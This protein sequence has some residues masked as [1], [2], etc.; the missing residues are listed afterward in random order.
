[1]RLGCAALAVVIAA[2]A[3]AATPPPTVAVAPRTA[4]E[5]APPLSE[6]PAVD[7]APPPASEEP[8][9]LADDDVKLTIP[10]DGLGIIPASGIAS[11]STAGK[12]IVALT[13]DSS[14]CYVTPIRR[15]TQ[16]LHLV[17]KDR[18]SRTIEIL[19]VDGTTACSRQTRLAVGEAKL[20]HVRDVR[21]FSMSPRTTPPIVDVAPFPDKGNILTITGRA[22]G[23]VT[24]W[25]LPRAAGDPVRCIAIDVT[26]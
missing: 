9:V 7:E 17:K 6:P 10:I 15:G 16:V 11:Y 5:P 18:S 3:C 21:T 14:S 20:E 4:P 25:T 2:P 26:S 1:M 22:P 19:V 8:I 13:P 12:G 23:R 24:L